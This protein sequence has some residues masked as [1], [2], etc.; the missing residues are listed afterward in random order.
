MDVIMVQQKLHFHI[1][2]M[3]HHT[4]SL[5]RHTVNTTLDLVPSQSVLPGGV[6]GEANMS[7]RHV[8]WEL[9]YPVLLVNICMHI[10]EI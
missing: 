7:Y 6:E 4:T 9:H 3:A 2:M 10:S 5:A 1:T 8:L